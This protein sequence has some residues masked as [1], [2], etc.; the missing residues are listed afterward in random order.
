MDLTSFGG[1]RDSGD[2]HLGS[3]ICGMEYRYEANR[4]G[5]SVRDSLDALPVSHEFS[6]DSVIIISEG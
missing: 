6:L 2:Q 1:I 3:S 4:C 5:H